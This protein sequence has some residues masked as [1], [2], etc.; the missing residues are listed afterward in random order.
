VAFDNFRIE[1]IPEASAT[2]LLGLGVL[3]LLRR[4][5]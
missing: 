3:G 1:T 4:R 2:V 5:R